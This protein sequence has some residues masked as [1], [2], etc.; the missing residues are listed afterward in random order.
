[1]G[2]LDRLVQ[3]G[4]PYSVGNGATPAINPL[5]TQ[6]SKLHGDGNA[7]GYSLNGSNFTDVN[8]AYQAYNDG[9]LNIL[10]QPSVLDRD[11]VTPPRYI[12][13]LPG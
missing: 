8:D 7:P 1:M 2:L 5:S 6:Q 9:A 11:G 3:G 4:S 12:D 10:P 13:N